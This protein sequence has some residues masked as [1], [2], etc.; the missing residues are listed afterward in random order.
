[1]ADIHEFAY[2]FAYETL[3]KI[4]IFKK[5]FGGISETVVIIAAVDKVLGEKVNSALL[6]KFFH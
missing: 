4:H 3:Y 5:F 1:M 6:F 2:R